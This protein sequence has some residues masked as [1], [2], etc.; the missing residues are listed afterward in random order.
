MKKK[1]ILDLKMKSIISVL[2]ILGVILYA[3][4]IKAAD[5]KDVIIGT[6]IGGIIGSEIQKG[7]QQPTVPQYTHQGVI[8]LP[9]GT[10][11]IP[12]Q[13]RKA[14]EFKYVAPFNP[15]DNSLRV[16]DWMWDRYTREWRYSKDCSNA[17]D[18]SRCRLGN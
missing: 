5:S 11:I 1:I 12:G 6:I 16:G 14:N 18:Y 13:A 8:H 17:R 4:P 2:I 10:I 3:A 7:K 15:T 9:D